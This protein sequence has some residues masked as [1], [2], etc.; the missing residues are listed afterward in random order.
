MD[1]ANQRRWALAV[2]ASVAALLVAGAIF[3]SGGGRAPAPPPP[4]AVQPGGGGAGGGGPQV[5]VGAT[6][7]TQ[8]RGAQTHPLWWSSSTADFDHELDLLHDAHGTVVRIDLAWS[9]LETDGKGK[10]SQWYV[11][12]AGLFLQHAAA[13]GISVIATLWASPCW[14]SSAPDSVKQGCAGAWWDRGVDR[15]APAN[16]TDYADAAAWVAQKWGS[17]LAALEIWNEPNLPDQYSLKAPD[18]AV[19]DAAMLKAAYPR[20]K[21]VA[22]SLTVLGGAL[23]FSDGDFLTRLYNA[24]IHGNFDAFS[25]HPYNEWRDPDDPWKPEYKKY[26]FLTGVPWIESILAAH[27]DGPLWLT[28]FGFSTCAG[29]SWCVTQAQQAE[30]IGD[31]YRI[32][33]T[34]PYVKAAI[35]YNLRNKG[36]STG[37][38]DQFG[39][40]NRDFTLKPAYAAFQTALAAP[41]APAPVDTKPPAGTPAVPETTTAT[42]LPA[43][44][45][46]AAP[47]PFTAAVGVITRPTGSAATVAVSVRCAP[48]AAK[49]CRGTVLVRDARGKLL[50]TARLNAA[51]GVSIVRPRLTPAGIVA[52]KRGGRLRL[53]VTVTAAKG[54]RIVHI[55]TAA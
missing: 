30:Y 27:G 38:E 55:A 41:A 42:P 7:S 51:R 17:Q 48:A 10:F 20:I 23:A 18:P 11:D 43:I 13:R 26:T 52:F 54:L 39:M 53:F 45:P 33:A 35:A 34:W 5:G 36:T 49:R 22:P 16:P 21:A 6:G 3:S 25:I 32:A 28:E 50:G 44:S 4:I 29:D 47:L 12:K 19:A 1:V 37:R 14:A 8:I 24:G 40:V 2:V 31:S 9:S 15:Y 46:E